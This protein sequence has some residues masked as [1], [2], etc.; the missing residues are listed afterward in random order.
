M[1]WDGLP[2]RSESGGGQHFV[3]GPRGSAGPAH[4]H[5]S[6]RSL[7]PIADSQAGAGF[8]LSVLEQSHKG[9]SK[10]GE[11]EEALISL[12]WLRLL[13]CDP[14]R[15]MAQGADCQ[16]N[17]S[18]RFPY[19]PTLFSRQLASGG[20]QNH[21][22]HLACHHGKRHVEHFPCSLMPESHCL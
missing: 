6:V 4:L 9:C 18:R 10:T 1:P 12:S 11:G 13:L 20:G 15:W 22:S 7:Y 3:S 14:G 16:P 2:P 17:P 8:K 19:S 5:L 21:T